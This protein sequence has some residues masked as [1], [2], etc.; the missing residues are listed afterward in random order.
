MKDIALQTARNSRHS[1]QI[2]REYL[3]NDILGSLQETGAGTHLYFVGGT[4]LRFLYRIPRF[5]ED[6]DFS[7]APG[8]RVAGF[9]PKMKKI[10]A[11]LGLAGY[12][13]SLSMNE[14]RI[15]QRAEFRF[16]KLLF[17]LRLTDRPE[18]KLTIAVEVDARPPRGWS[19]ERTI[20]N[21][22]RPILIRHY[23]L[24]SLFTAKIAALLTR[25]YAKGRDYY[26][27]F[28]YLSRWKDLKPAPLLLKNALA[29]KRE[30]IPNFRPEAWRGILESI[31]AEADWRVVARDV[32][33]F[34]ERAEDIR[35]FSRENLLRVLRSHRPG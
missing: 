12:D 20:V 17:D 35:V 21:L 13:L 22:Y 11:E 23:D 1:L 18:Q 14:D 16:P 33:P 28:W 15:V 8:W 30:S 29:Q 27:L 24:K 32:S 9:G 10:Q 4:A 19:G 2:L 7:A 6:L 5:S 26:D 3:Q 34:L 25:P 31:V